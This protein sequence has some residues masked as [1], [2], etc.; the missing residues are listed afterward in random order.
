MSFPKDDLSS[1][2]VLLSE[3][4]FMVLTKDLPCNL[5][6]DMGD[7]LEDKFDEKFASV[8]SDRNAN[9]S[10]AVMVYQSNSACH[11]P[12]IENWPGEYNLE[13]LV[14]G[15]SSSK[16]TWLFSYELNKIFVDV[17]QSIP[18][19]FK[20]SHRPADDPIF[21]RAMAVYDVTQH[22][23]IPVKRCP[24]HLKEDEDRGLENIEHV[25]H[26]RDKSA[27]YEYDNTSKRYS[28]VVPFDAPPAGSDVTT[29]M[30]CVT[31]KGSCTGGMNR[32]PVMLIFTL[33]KENRQVVGRRTLKIRVCSC[34]KRDKRKEEAEIKEMG[35]K[36]FPSDN[37]KK[38]VMAPKPQ[39]PSAHEPV[40]KKMKDLY[41]SF[42]DSSESQ[43]VYNIQ[44]T[45]RRHYVEM[46]QYAKML[47]TCEWVETHSDNVLQEKE[48]FENL[49][50]SALK[51]RAT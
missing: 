19:Q 16:K 44:I 18:L 49:L 1:Q 2:E 30:Y 29:L 7:L 3:G 28:V 41:S 40:T 24:N 21:L 4:E 23:H 47:K 51:G 39:T 46:L 31:C 45:G 9:C 33:E 12:C 15:V 50:E 8:D 35:S 17:N 27:I 26:C 22:I 34:P 14:D 6:N 38:K 36:V 48:T 37:N 32:R 25:L 13:L 11:I 5:L 42:Y 10:E 20:L 43:E